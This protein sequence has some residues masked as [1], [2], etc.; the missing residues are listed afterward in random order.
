MAIRFSFYFS[1]MKITT[2]NLKK[3]EDLMDEADYVVRYE[4]GNFKSGYCILKD[5]RVIVIS[6][7]FDTESR[8][9]TFIDL[10]PLLDI[11]ETK[12]EEK[13][14]QFLHQLREEKVQA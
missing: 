2:T 14:Q 1:P 3:I 7:F 5:K 4:K 12:L 6:K 11:D 9:N 10:I 13:S 8:I